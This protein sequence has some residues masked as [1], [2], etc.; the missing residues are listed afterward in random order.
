M[1]LAFYAPL[2]APDHP[3]P[4]GDR[5]MARALIAALEYGGATVTLAS[6]LRTRDGGGDAGLQTQLLDQAQGEITRLCG[7]GQTEGWQAWVTYHNYYKAPDLIGPSVA[8]HLGIPYLLI[9]ASRA[10]KR[11]TGPWARFAQAAE[12]ASDAA[13]VIYYFTH[14]DAETLERDRAGTQQLIHL[15][16]FLMR[17]SVDDAAVP[18]GPMLAVGMLREGDKLASY[19]IIAETLAQLPD[20]DWSLRIA[21]DGAARAHVEALMAPFGTSV[22]FLGQLDADELIDVYR[23]SSLLFWPGVNEAFG[24]AYLEGQAAGL[25]VV[26]QD[27]PGVRDVL[28]PG[29]YPDPVEGVLPLATRLQQ[30]LND[31][32]LR[33][34]LGHAAQAHVA[35]HHLLSAASATLFSGL[36]K[37]GVFR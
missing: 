7:V 11:L 25:P 2:K 10:R 26:A 20:I 33:H 1:R 21:G 35:A 8:R 37:C 30:L 5:A 14:R 34:R 3:T 31:P 24:L 22:Q 13:D 28:A 32:A 17:D 23:T 9:E 12:I 6:P 4:S 29:D 16:P 15:P 19:Q 18:D 36:A 27:R